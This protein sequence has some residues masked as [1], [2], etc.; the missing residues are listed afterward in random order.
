EKGFIAVQKALSLNPSSAE[1]YVVR[2]VL[3][4]N[5]GHSY[6]IAAAIK[7]YRHAIV[8]KPNLA[9]AHHALGSKLTHLGLH[10]QAIEEFRNALRLDPQLQG[11]KLRLGRALWQSN[12]FAEALASYE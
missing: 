6:D 7:D 11:A 12:R 9:S 5:R 4:Y 1:G 10:D 8:L 3:N 2:G